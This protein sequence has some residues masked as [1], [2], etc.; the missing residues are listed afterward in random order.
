MKGCHSKWMLLC[1]VGV[2][3]LFL[4]V[5]EI[6]YALA[7]LPFWALAAF[8]VGCCALPVLYG[9]SRSSSPK[10]KTGACCNKG[11]R[12]AE[13]DVEEEATRRPKKPS[14]H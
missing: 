4:V 13:A 6:S 11:G 14:C 9:A 2:G 5:L 12:A 10:E 3:M 7:E 1:L 8:M